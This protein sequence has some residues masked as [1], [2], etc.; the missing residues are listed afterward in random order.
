MVGNWGSC[1]TLYERVR[2]KA[3][4]E[5]AEQLAAY[6]EA[7][8]GIA[9]RHKWEAV[10]RYD[11]CFRLEDAD[12]PEVKWECLDGSLLIRELVLTAECS[13]RSTAGAG[14]KNG[15][16]GGSSFS[17]RRE[18]RQQGTCF[19]FNRQNGNCA[20]GSQCRFLHACS[21]C[22]GDHPATQCNSKQQGKSQKVE[23][24]GIQ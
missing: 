14:H 11:P 21:G 19:R 5:M 1:F 23:A 12:K 4:P 18:K 16:S 22:G 9:R 20:F 17:Q 7:V 10:A 6:R 24:G 3:N 13:G 8:V 2:V 15:Q